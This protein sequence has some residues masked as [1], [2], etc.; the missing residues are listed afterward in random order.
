MA[1]ASLGKAYVQ[2][3]PSAEGVSGAISGIFKKEG[4]PA[5]AGFGKSIVGF[6]TKAI[7][8]GGIAKA[9]TATVK[10]GAR[11]E[12][13]KGGIETLFKGAE[14]TMIQYANNAWKTAGISASDYME[15]STSFAAS[16]LQSLKGDTAAA[17][18]AANQA[19]VDM[20]DNANKFGT[21]IADIQHAY[22]GFAKGNYSM[23]D[24]LNTM[25]ALAA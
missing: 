25:G 20:S 4:E 9:L 15:Q 18:E 24:N 1:R 7:L 19:V 10:E 21:N 16:L 5:G 11:Y 17:A 3:V 12:Q 13:A 6:A 8:A 14:D 2:I 23:L 22:Q